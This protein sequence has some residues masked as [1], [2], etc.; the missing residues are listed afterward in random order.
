MIAST[1]VSSS[2]SATPGDILLRVGSADANNGGRVILAAGN[3]VGDSA[4]GGH[5][6]IYAG[7]GES[8]DKLDERRRRQY[9]YHR[10]KRSWTTF[11]RQRWGCGRCSGKLRN[12]VKGGISHWQRDKERLGIVATYVSLPP[13]GARV[14]QEWTV[15]A[16]TGSG[17]I[18][19]GDIVMH[20]DDARGLVGSVSV[21]AG[22]SVSGKGAV[23][24]IQAGPSATENGGSFQLVSGSG[25]L[26]SGNVTL[27]TALH[28]MWAQQAQL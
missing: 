5:V 14:Q 7:S 22:S 20:S 11:Y 27:T 19:S 3:M 15:I 12:L 26:R 2:A 6:G 23:V 16:E 25:R 17:A 10:R 8:I 9:I 28:P 18:F 4:T 1:G 21:K 13:M 24:S